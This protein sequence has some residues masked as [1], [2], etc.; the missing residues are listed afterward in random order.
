[1]MRRSRWRIRTRCLKNGAIDLAAASSVLGDDA[2]VDGDALT[3]SSIRTGNVAATNGAQGEIGST[4]VGAYGVLTLNADGQYSY[5]TTASAVDGLAAGATAVDVFTYTITDGALSA[6]A[7]L[8]ITVTGVNDAP[9]AVANTNEVP[10]NGAIDLAAASSVLGDDADVDGDA[11]TVS[12]IRTGNVAATNGAQGEIGSTLVGAYGVLTLN[13]DGQYSYATTASAVDGLAAGATAVDVFTYT[14]T[15]GALSASAEL[16]I[17][18]T[19]VND[20][21]V[22]AGAGGTVI[23]SLDDIPNVE[24]GTS[25][26]GTSSTGTSSYTAVI[27]S[28]LAV[29]DVDD[30]VIEG[31]TISISSG[32]V[33]RRG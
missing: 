5:A 8:L 20:A 28:S 15:D 1:M 9:I 29:S 12:S 2:D 18:V 6:S 11:L 25:S 31:A 23:F 10:E 30:V 22:L 7:E 4:L 3:V 16:L 24:G 13:A 32:F 21:P 33:L 27:D 14:I 19:G 17:T 26:T